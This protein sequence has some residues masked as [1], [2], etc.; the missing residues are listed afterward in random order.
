MKSYKKLYLQERYNI[1]ITSYNYDAPIKIFKYVTY[2]RKILDKLF[3]NQ[4]HKDLIN[5]TI[6]KL[7]KI[8]ADIETFEDETLDLLNTPLWEIKKRLLIYQEKCS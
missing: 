1:I 8:A 5:S 7:S 3:K 2:L 4:S 6:D